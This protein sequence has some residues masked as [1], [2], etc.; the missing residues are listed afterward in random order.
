MKVQNNRPRENPWVF[1]LPNAMGPASPGGRGLTA[2]GISGPVG[3]SEDNVPGSL[4]TARYS[5]GPMA[6]NL[7]T[8]GGTTSLR[9]P[10]W[11]SV[12]SFPWAPADT[13]E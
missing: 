11:A 2:Q 12:G 7:S 4:A 5:D 8:K 9:N 6:L 13:T 3:L 10:S 1:M